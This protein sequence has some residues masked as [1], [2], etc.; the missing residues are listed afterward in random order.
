M[1]IKSISQKIF[2]TSP[3]TIESNSN[4]TNP[5]GVSFKGN[6]ISADVFDSSAESKVSFGANIAAKVTNKSKMVASA[7]VGSI[8]DMNQAIS[9]RLDPIVNFGKRIGESASKAWNYLNNTNLSF[10][11]DASLDLVAR[12]TKDLFRVGNDYSKSHLKKLDP[13]LHIEA[14]FRELAYPKVLE[15]TV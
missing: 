12:K 3:K 1:E 4:H 8:N 2:K 7:I 15:A 5:F 6:M 9:K 10:K 14:M 11:L 13:E